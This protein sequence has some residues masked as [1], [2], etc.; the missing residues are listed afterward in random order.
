LADSEV[1]PMTGD[2]SGA[3]QQPPDGIDATV[4]HSARIWNYWLGGKDNYE[5]DRKVGDQVAELFPG[6]RETARVSRAL[7]ARVIGYL[8]AEA[9]VRQFLDVGTG[10][11]TANNTHEVAQQ[12]APESRIVYVDNDPLVL[13]YARALLTS[14]PEGA[15]YYVDAD[16]RDSDRIMSE[17]ASILD[18]TQP[19]ALMLNGIIGHIED[20]DEARACVRRLVA[21][22][23]PG[24]YLAMS[25]GTDT[26][27]TAVRST[28]L[29]KDSGAVPYHMRSPAVFV[30]FFD[31]LELVEPGI[32]PR[33]E[34]R[35][36]SAPRPLAVVPPQPA[37]NPPSLAGVARKPS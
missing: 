12:I 11:P 8:A 16:L 35:P 34:W 31:G 1:F 6:I 29:Y 13:V 2:H 19:T 23:P 36:D 5:V 9:G 10:L 27:R 7:Q 30:S 4:P 15:T 3:S 28:G 20:D 14:S 32:V 25:D 33:Q 26:D 18:F 17:A 22:L 21:A 24:S 37:V